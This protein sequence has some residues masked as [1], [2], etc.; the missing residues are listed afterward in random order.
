LAWRFRARLAVATGLVLLCFLL[1]VGFKEYAF[2]LAPLG[3][4]VAVCFAPRRKWLSAAVI[5]GAA[6]IA[7][8]V[9]IIIRRYVVPGVYQ[10]GFEYILLTPKQVAQNFTVMATG[11]LF[12]G[13]SVWVCVHWGRPVAALVGLVMLLS[14]SVIGAGIML[15]ARRGWGADLPLD[16]SPRRWIAFLFLSFVAASFPVWIMF[17]VSEMYLPQII[18]PLALLCGI[19][20]DG[21]RKAR[22]MVT[23]PIFALALAALVSSIWTIRAKV[24]GL[25]GVGDRAAAQIE[26]ILSFLPPDAHDKRIAIL[27]DSSQLPPRRTYAVYRMGDEVLLVHESVLDWP[28]PG[29]HLTLTSKTDEPLA[30][31]DKYDLILRWDAQEGRFA[32]SGP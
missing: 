15:A 11:L 1:A 3:G 30:D 6:C 32:K 16:R 2:A 31:P 19:A 7:I 29:K 5:G 4:L 27:F 24:A 23:V 13:D 18:V 20:A 9:I 17:H 28:R 22:K 12:F 21:Y 10:R 8:I 14:A 26:Q 25:R